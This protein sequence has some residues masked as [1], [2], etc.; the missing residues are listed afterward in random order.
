MTRRLAGLPEGREVRLGRNP[1][2]PCDGSS[3]PERG[4]GKCAVACAGFC[5]SE[6][7]GAARFAV[8][9][10]HANGVRTWRVQGQI[11]CMADEPRVPSKPLSPIDWMPKTS[12]WVSG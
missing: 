12:A 1:Q 2:H 9:P 4:V 6:A 7:P 10:A 11:A 3:L 5:R 8:F